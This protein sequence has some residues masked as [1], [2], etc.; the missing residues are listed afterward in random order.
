MEKIKKYRAKGLWGKSEIIQFKKLK[1]MNLN[2][3]VKPVTEKD[4]RRDF[5]KIGEVSSLLNLKPYVLRY[6]ETE[7]SELKPK[8]S[9]GNQRTYSKR[10][11]LLIQ[12][13]KHLLYKERF[14]IEG[15]C[16]VLKKMEQGEASVNTLP[17]S[18]I[19]VNETIQRV[20]FKVKQLLNKIAE[21]KQALV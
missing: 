15:A 19:V 9:K 5:Y 4:P 3:G 11:V 10:D 6:W 17:A 20:E 12:L 1:E 8:K 7:F 2:Y 16:S 14:S 13:I 18:S 21:L